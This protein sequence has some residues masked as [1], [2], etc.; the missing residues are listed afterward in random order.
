[1]LVRKL[2]RLFG[3]LLLVAGTNGEISKTNDQ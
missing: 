3:D 2:Q 1:M